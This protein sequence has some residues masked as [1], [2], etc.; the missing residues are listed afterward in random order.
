M[1]KEIELYWNDLTSEAQNHIREVLHMDA[2]DN[3]NWD[4]IPMTVLGF[5][6]EDDEE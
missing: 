5:E 1:Y 6:D 3:G 2:D 4:V